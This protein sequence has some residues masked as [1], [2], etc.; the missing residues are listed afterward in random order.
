MTAVCR[1]TRM[2]LNKAGCLRAMEWELI[3]FAYGWVV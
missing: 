2:G 3:D 1:L